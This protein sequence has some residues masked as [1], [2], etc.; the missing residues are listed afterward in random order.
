MDYVIGGIKVVVTGDS[1]GLQIAFDK[2]EKGFDRFRKK[3]KKTADSVGNDLKRISSFAKLYIGSRIG[4]WLGRGAK[5]FLDTAESV[6]KLKISLISLER[7]VDKGLATFDRL[8]AWAKDMPINTSE[9]INQYRKLTAMGLKPTEEQMELILDTVSA[10]GGR[11]ET[12]QGIARALG[13]MA[14]K[15]KIAGEEMRQLAEHGFPI[16]EVLKDKLQLTG[17]QLRDMNRQGVDA[18]TGLNAIFSGMADMFGGTSAAMMKT[19]FG[20]TQLMED[21]WWRFQR[22]FMDNDI[23]A[24]LKAGLLTFFKMFDGQTKAMGVAL[25]ETFKSLLSFLF[26]V[27]LGAAQMIDPFIPI[28]DIIYDHIIKPLMDAFEKLPPFMKTLG[29]IGGL[30]LGPSVGFVIASVGV[31]YQKAVDMANFLDVLSGG[32]LEEGGIMG[33]ILGGVKDFDDWI[34]DLAVKF[35][36]I[37]NTSG[38]MFTKASD[39]LK[40]FRADMM[41]LMPEMLS[42]SAEFGGSSGPVGDFGVDTSGSKSKAN[43]LHDLAIEI[44]NDAA[45]AYGIFTGISDK[46][47]ELIKQ[48]KDWHL[49]AEGLSRPYQSVEAAIKE[50]N[51]VIREI[52]EKNNTWLNGLIDGAA[53]YAE[54]VGT[55]RS[56]WSEFASSTLNSIEEGFADI[57]ISATKGFRD[58]GDVAKRILNE[59]LNQMIR[60]LFIQRLV[61][62]IAGAAGVAPEVKAEIKHT[63]DKSGVS[64]SMPSAMFNGA[65]RLHNGLVAGE[66]PAILQRGESVIPRGQSIGGNIS[67]NIV[68]QRQSGAPVDV[69]Q[70]TGP[71]GEKR[72][73]AIIR[74]AVKGMM[75]D[76]SFDRT[77]Q[78][79]YG[80]SRKGR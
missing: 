78:L 67:I 65:P 52:N 9:A 58:L 55:I 27:L 68:D 76:G 6:E 63:G 3:S 69:Q 20:T 18:V 35:E 26:D 1:K 7:D 30:L 56:A 43:D 61:G 21:R 60:I 32:K 46:V 5:S 16:Y 42:F 19:W 11:V 40:K 2:A 49:L 64:R 12:F 75:S 53:K 15:G 54:K 50:Y 72:I 22:G 45:R 70:T 14:S 48:N 57:F 28:F 80:I 66:Y 39:A 4:M 37:N 62:S 25:A 13:Q 71:D 33:Q 8:D 17:D 73:T 79:N 24:G 41:A 44:Y 36:F 10:L 59:I 34:K 31:L 51:R 77:Y 29:L 38:R 74:D 47:Y 23:F